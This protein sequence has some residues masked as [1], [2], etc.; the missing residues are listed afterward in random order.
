MTTPHPGKSLESQPS[1]PLLKS[2]RGWAAPADPRLR[3]LRPPRETRGGASIGLHDHRLPEEEVIR[4]QR[5]SA[6]S[7]CRLRSFVLPETRHIWR[8]WPIS[9]DTRH[10]CGQRL[11]S[12]DMAHIGTTSRICGYDS[13]LQVRLISRDNEASGGDACGSVWGLATATR[14]RGLRDVSI[15]QVLNSSKE[16]GE[17]WDRR[18]ESWRLSGFFLETT[19]K[20][21]EEP[22]GRQR[23]QEGGSRGAAGR[24]APEGRRTRGRSSARRQAAASRFR[25]IEPVAC[26]KVSMCIVCYKI[27]GLVRRRSG[28]VPGDS[29]GSRSR[30]CTDRWIGTS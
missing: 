5:S 27:Q 21:E 2:A 4:R 24:A 16:E 9:A 22:A 17:E 12:T 18:V 8:Q 30:R 25:G 6:V 28:Q 14:V 7:R 29:C 26:F 13:Y 3:A 15:P 1:V 23:S 20:K 19:R 10:I 11:V